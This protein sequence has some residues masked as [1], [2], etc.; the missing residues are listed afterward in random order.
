MENTRYCWGSYTDVAVGEA[1]NGIPWWV[2]LRRDKY[3]YI[4]WLVPG[5]IEEMY[6]LEEDPE[7]LVNLALEAEYH[8]LLA[9]MRAGREP[10]PFIL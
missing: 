5:E 9:E 10:A 3:K 7:E 2:S 6:N 4:R 8:E 1:E